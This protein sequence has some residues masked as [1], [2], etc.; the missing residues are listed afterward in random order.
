MKTI[1]A[2]ILGLLLPSIA[3]AHG[4]ADNHLLIVLAEHRAKL[5]I[6]VDMRVLRLVD[7]DGDG[8]ASLDELREKRATLDSYTGKLFAMRNEDGDEG[9]LV[10]SDTTANLRVADENGGRV[11]HAR[12]LRTVEFDATP[13]TILLDLA[14]I[15]EAIPGAHVTIV[16]STTG[17]RRSIQ[18]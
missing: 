5:T 4:K 12:I 16:N 7:V 11:D 15:A 6:T 10:F 13:E 9:R 2:L 8:F 1:V 17:G 18:L 3:L 14:T